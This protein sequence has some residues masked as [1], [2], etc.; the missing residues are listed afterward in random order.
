TK[1][2]TDIS[3]IYDNSVLVTFFQLVGSIDTLNSEIL[4]AEVLKLKGV[5]AFK[6]FYNRI[7]KIWM[8]STVTAESVR[9]K[10]LQQNIDFDIKTIETSDAQV[11]SELSE[12]KLITPA[13]TL[14]VAIPS[15]E[16]I[17]PDNFPDY[18]DTGNPQLDT[19][20][21]AKAKQEWI[22]N[23]PEAYKKMTGVE[24]LGKR[25]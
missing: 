17:Y 25:N 13:S 2:N 19:E 8:D 6:V 11:I 1:G 18:I 3:E 16:W 24:H 10:L 4:T 22:N 12:K 5:I 14:P 9:E 23:N 21:F 20:N 15:N 7:C